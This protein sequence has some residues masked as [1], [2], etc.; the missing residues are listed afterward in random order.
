MKLLITVLAGLLWQ[1]PLNAS[2]L[3]LLQAHVP[4]AVRHSSESVVELL[5][6]GKFRPFSPD[7]LAERERIKRLSTGPWNGV[8]EF[9]NSP[10][11]LHRFFLSLLPNMPLMPE[12][13]LVSGT[14][15]LLGDGSYILTARHVAEGFIAA[16]ERQIL[17]ATRVESERELQ[18]RVS[19]LTFGVEIKNVHGELVHFSGKQNR[20]RVVYYNGP[21]DKE[22]LLLERLTDVALIQLDKPIGKG[23]ELRPRR[24]RLSEQVW[25]VGFPT[26]TSS[27][28]HVSRGEVVKPLELPKSMPHVVREFYDY[29]AMDA[30]LPSPPGFSGGPLFSEDGSLAGVMAVSDLGE[31]P[32]TYGISAQ[33]VVALLKEAG[34]FDDLITFP[35]CDK[36]MKKKPTAN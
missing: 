5:C 20:A 32:R 11:E 13:P 1:S 28:A 14:G 24:P 15:V 25:G 35:D 36:R 21:I 34:K 30:A 23:L 9:M 27:V 16:A 10:L 19:E 29:L 2:P 7:D 17:R 4:Q 31:P 33:G 8:A 3:P 12:P 6:G 22:V 18:D 26:E